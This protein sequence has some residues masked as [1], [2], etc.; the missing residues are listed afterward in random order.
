MFVVRLL[1]WLTGYLKIVISGRFPERFVNLAARKGLNLWNMVNENNDIIVFAKRS[2]LNELYGIA[3]KTGNTLHI[4]REYGLPELLGRYKCRCGLLAGLALSAGLYFFMSGFVWNITVKVPDSINEYE[5]R[6]V[7]RDCGVYEGMRS[8]SVN[9]DA[10]VDHICSTDSRISWMTIN[11]S[12]TDAE[13]CIS[14]RLPKPEKAL[15]DTQFSNIKSIA[16]GTVTRVNVYKGTANVSPGD[17][18]RK[19]QLLVSGLVEYNNGKT[20]L[21]DA[22]AR[23]FAKTHRSVSITIP[24]KTEKIKASDMTIKRDITIFGLTL[25]LS[26]SSGRN[27]SFTKQASRKD[28]TILEH[29]IPISISEEMWQGYK[30]EPAVLSRPQ[31]E[32]ILKNRLSLYE[33][34]MLASAD[35]ARIMERRCTVADDGEG[36]TLKA[37]YDIEENVCTKT[38]VNTEI[39]AAE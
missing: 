14:P 9:T 12:G 19:N 25:P 17:G 35:R 32:A 27:D 26:L 10:I 34:F 2:D 22:Q 13:V 33:F 16:D 36:F 6:A 28:L 11:I 3:E 38:I 20:I 21:T 5:I 7:L 4:L 39:N 8:S 1:T 29:R 15:N 30:K 24:K 37:E 23:V 31:A 18:I